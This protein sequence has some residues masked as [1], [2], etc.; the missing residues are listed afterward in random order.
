M[1]MRINRIILRIS[2][3][4][5][6][7]IWITQKMNKIKNNIKAKNSE[8]WIIFSYL[9]ILILARKKFLDKFLIFETFMIFFINIIL[10]HNKY[11]N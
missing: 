6:S 11:L 9:L 1:V 8:I 10:I 5:N 7:K 3:I 2:N 4:K